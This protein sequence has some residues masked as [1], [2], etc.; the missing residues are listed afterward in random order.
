MNKFCL[1]LAPPPQKSFLRHWSEMLSLII[2]CEYLQ[3][4]ILRCVKLFHVTDFGKF[5]YLVN[6]RQ[7]I[8][9]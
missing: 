3:T 5:V 4:C 7:N 8:M 9:Q 1:E 6:L 2:T